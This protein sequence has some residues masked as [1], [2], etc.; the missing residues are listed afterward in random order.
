MSPSE[1]YIVTK[2]HGDKLDIERLSGLSLFLYPKLFV[3]QALDEDGVVMGV[4]LYTYH[5]LEEL[6]GIVQSDEFIQSPNTFGRLFV[7]LE[8]MSLVPT[9]LFDPTHKN[10]YLSFSQPLEEE[11]CEAFHQG[12]YHNTIQVLGTM[13][14]G[15]LAF[16]DHALPELEVQ[17]GAVMHLECMLNASRNSSGEIIIASIVPDGAY[18]AAIKEGQLK[19][20]NLFRIVNEKEFLKYGLS[21]IQQLGFNRTILETHLMGELSYIGCTLEG[22]RPYFHEI[23][24]SSPENSIT[25]YSGAEHF[26]NTGLLEAYW[27]I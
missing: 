5:T 23:T 14:K 11:E 8:Q 20:F 1:N 18:F 26:K 24:T 13:N 21:I 2:F 25:Y 3:I 15:V 17:H 4:S 6:E 12:A 9:T 22:L 27:S 16:M 7:H 19:L 10:T